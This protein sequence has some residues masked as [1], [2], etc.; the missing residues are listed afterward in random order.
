MILWAI[1]DTVIIKF[2]PPYDS[3]KSVDEN[4]LESN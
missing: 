3:R 2:F 4:E 1:L